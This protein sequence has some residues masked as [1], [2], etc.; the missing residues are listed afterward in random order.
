M[1]DELH[2]SYSRN[3]ANQ[4]V[5][6]GL[7]KFAKARGLSSPEIWQHNGEWAMR[8]TGT[9]GEVKQ[10]SLGQV[11]AK[12]RSVIAS[13][14][15]PKVALAEPQAI[16]KELMQRAQAVGLKTARITFD[17]K[18]YR[19]QYGGRLIPLGPSRGEAMAKIGKVK[20][21]APKVALSIDVRTLKPRMIAS[22]AAASITSDSLTPPTPR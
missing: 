13:L 20:P 16:V 15:A 17:G 10:L 8:Y 2:A 19:M 12:A 4:S 9:D 18:N 11:F 7:I 21:S 1:S 14:S 5:Q 22:E 3:L 6:K